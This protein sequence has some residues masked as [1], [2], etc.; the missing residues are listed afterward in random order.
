M[1]ATRRR[2]EPEYVPLVLV[3]ETQKEED[4]LREALLAYTK[5]A[6]TM[7]VS[8][9]ASALVGDMRCADTNHA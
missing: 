6:S 3:T 8:L 4:V 1:K 7:Q 9:T 2:K 5:S